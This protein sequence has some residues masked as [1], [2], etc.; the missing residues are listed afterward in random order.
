MAR[1]TL[2]AL[3]PARPDPHHAGPYLVQGMIR[4]DLQSLAAD[5]NPLR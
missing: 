5:N 2:Y 3:M 1:V 4:F